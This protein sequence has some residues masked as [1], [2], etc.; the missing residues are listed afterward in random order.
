MPDALK[1]CSTRFGES[2]YLPFYVQGGF[3]VNTSRM[4]KTAVLNQTREAST[5]SGPLCVGAYKNLQVK[6]VKH[7]GKIQYH[8]KKTEMSNMANMVR[9]KK[10]PARVH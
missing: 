5:R 6:Q 1:N 2:I 8:P 4:K 9:S 7:V 10:N 3:F